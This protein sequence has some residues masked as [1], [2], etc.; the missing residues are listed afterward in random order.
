MW[1]SLR[2]E[3]TAEE[4]GRAET[5]KQYCPWLVCGMAMRSAWGRT[6]EVKAVEWYEALR[7]PLES[8]E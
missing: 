5:L 7:G 8:F 2:W 4:I 1:F 3:Q 6:E